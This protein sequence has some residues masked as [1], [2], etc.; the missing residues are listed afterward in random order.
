[1]FISTSY[2]HF[3]VLFSTVEYYCIIMMLY[4]SI[5]IYIYRLKLHQC[6]IVKFSTSAHFSDLCSQQKVLVRQ[7]AFYE[8]ILIARGDSW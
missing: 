4:K 8:D 7:N 3:I 6:N 1:M 2:V 5:N